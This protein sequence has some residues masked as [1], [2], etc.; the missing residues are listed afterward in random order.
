MSGEFNGLQALI[1]NNCQYAYY[2]HCFA[3]RLQLALV[4]AARE[5]VEVHQFFKDLSD[6]VNI[7]SASFKR[8]NELQKAQA[9]E[10]TRLVSIN[11]LATGT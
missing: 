8:H 2:V 7:S 10:I 3:H 9:A 11:E 1:L 6:I 5:V 4:A